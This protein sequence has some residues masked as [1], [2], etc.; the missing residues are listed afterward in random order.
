[1]LMKRLFGILCVFV[2]LC[3]ARAADP[4]VEEKIKA[5]RTKYAQIEKALKDCR[6]VKRDLPGESAEGGELTAWFRDRSVTKLSAMFYGES[7][8]ALEQ[9]Y[10]W[11]SELIFVFRVD[12]HY[13]Q[14]TSGVVK[15]KTEDRFYFADGKLI[16][17]LDPAKKEVT[18]GVSERE[19]DLLARAKK[20]SA[21]A[22]Q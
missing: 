17:W 3:S 16:R 8:K 21:T 11:D 12:W 18:T 14:P 10:F 19:R 5:I 1:M 20:Y 2:A 9:Y 13:T 22:N 4:A 7:G 15:N 6:Q